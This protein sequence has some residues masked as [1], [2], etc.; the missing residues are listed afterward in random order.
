M[1]QL[2]LFDVVSKKHLIHIII[3]FIFFYKYS[4]GLN[5][6]DH[7]FFNFFYYFVLLALFTIVLIPLDFILKQKK[8]NNSVKI[9]LIYILSIIFFN[10]FLLTTKQNC[11]DWRKGLNN[12]FIEN[13][14]SKY[15]CQIQIPKTCIYKLLEYFQDYSKLLKKTCE[16]KKKGEFLRKK[17]LKLSHSPFINNETKLIGYPLFNKDLK[18]FLDFSNNLYNYFLNNLID[19]ENNKLLNTYIKE[20]I[21]EVI[22]NF[23]NINEPKMVINLCFNKS[24]SKERK[25]FEKNSEPF[26]NNI[27][28]LYLDSL[29]RSNALRQLKK[30]T[31]F[32]E[33]FMSYKGAFHD[34]HPFEKFHS[35]QFFKYHSFKGYTTVNYP[36]LFYGQNRFNKNKTLITKFFKENG[37]ITSVANDWCGIDNIKTYHNFSKEDIYDHIFLICDPNNEHY[38]SNTI[39]CLYGKHNI[40]YLLDYTN[41][42]WGKY[43]NN[44][45]YSMIISN[46]AHEGTLTVVKHIDEIIA[47]F[48]NSL[49]KENLLK[50]STIF[51]L[52]DHGVGL[53]SIYY[54]SEFYRLEINLPV[55]LL[56]INDRKNITYEDQYKYIYEN[57]QTFITPFDIYNLLGN[58]LYGNKYKA[59][60]NMTKNIITC[61]SSYGI[62]LFEKINPKERYPMKY[63][64]IGEMGISR[65]SCK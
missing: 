5:F 64:N 33:K 30:T 1:L 63:K 29:S 13:D 39:R 4:H 41:Q 12:T 19:M 6:N 65:G 15:G 42:F 28:I 62:S 10:L 20:K 34:K 61:K 3:I 57:Q 38:N 31:K 32:F 59:I 36:F 7:G 53:P 9:I 27:L 8:T 35:F 58:L 48:L 23:T 40:E 37:F 2:M 49:F 51:L 11:T 47:N 44:R 14:K 52:S 22:I 25:L 50:D 17:I 26:S 55:L 60:K 46:Y 56:I 43:K 18:A 24:L 21:P 16:D 54:T 45:K